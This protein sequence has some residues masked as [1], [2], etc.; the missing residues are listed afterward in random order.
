M[1]PRNTII[2]LA[3]LVLEGKDAAA[4]KL[5]R[6]VYK[7]YKRKAPPKPSAVPDEPAE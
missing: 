6:K 4:D 1:N 7:H 2:E 5:A 3:Q